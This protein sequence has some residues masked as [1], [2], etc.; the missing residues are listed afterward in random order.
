VVPQV[1]GL[2]AAQSSFGSVPALT[3]RHSPFGRPVSALLHARQVP[4]HGESQQKP[5]TQLPDVHSAVREQANPFG[6]SGA[7]LPAAQ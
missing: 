6:L 4:V 3:G 7:Q 5:F 1:A 2:C